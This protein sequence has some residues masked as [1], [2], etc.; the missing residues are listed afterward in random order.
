MGD[1]L[2]GIHGSGVRVEAGRH[3]FGDHWLE[4]GVA[5]K[6]ECRQRGQRPKEWVRGHQCGESLGAIF[7]VSSEIQVECPQLGNPT[8]NQ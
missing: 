5:Q 6:S 2:S 1:M 4:A 8:L 7:E 3:H